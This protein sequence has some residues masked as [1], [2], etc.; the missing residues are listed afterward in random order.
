M[1]TP[2]HAAFLRAV[3]LGS[4]RKAPSA[5]LVA[6]FEQAGFEDVATFRTS[7]NVAFR[8]TGSSGKD[9]LTERIEAGLLEELG[10]EVPVFLR[11]EAELEAIAA[12]RPFPAMAVESSKGKVQVALLLDKPPA[13]AKKRVMSLASQDDRLT[14]DGS[15][16]YW[17][18]SG[19]TQK[20]SLNM[21]AIDTALGLNTLRTQGTIE[22]M[23]AKFFG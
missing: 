12:K 4:T 3:N 21:K 15:E 8:A 22:A 14:L 20:S 1:G 6:A 19:G 10:F 9:K 2:T 5:Q 23:A 7:G 11:T 17:L 13:A 18:P 16:L